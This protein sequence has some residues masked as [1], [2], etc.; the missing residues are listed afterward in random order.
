M[1]E[2]GPTFQASHSSIRLS[3]QI[4]TPVLLHWKK[5]VIFKSLL[6]WHGRYGIFNHHGGHAMGSSW[7]VISAIGI[8]EDSVANLANGGFVDLMTTFIMSP[9]ARDVTELF[10]TLQASDSTVRQPGQQSSILLIFTFV[11]CKMNCGQWRSSKNEVFGTQKYH[12]ICLDIPWVWRKWLSL[13]WTFLKKFW[14]ILHLAGSLAWWAVS[15][16]RL[17]LL[18]LLS[19]FPHSRQATLPLGNLAKD[20]TTIS[21]SSSKAAA[22]RLQI[23]FWSW[24][25]HNSGFKHGLREP[26]WLSQ[27]FIVAIN[28]FECSLAKFALDF[29][30]ILMSTSIVSFAVAHVGKGLKTF[31]TSDSTIGSTCQSFLL[32]NADDHLSK[33]CRFTTYKE[34]CGFGLG[35]ILDFNW[36]L[37]KPW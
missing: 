2:F 1:A 14:Q 27:M 28:V 4:F 17:A 24:L 36:R 31:E 12:F 33:F 11:D 30:Q 34:E 25:G 5:S 37:S 35:T 19:C 29:G 20:P 26:M 13:V 22:K 16:C 15:K 18:R 10:S 3:R 9:C 8:L 7:M 6:R 21:L 23:R 32:F